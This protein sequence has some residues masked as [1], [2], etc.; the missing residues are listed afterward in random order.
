MI[1][2]D[3][4]NAEK[5][6][7][8]E[9]DRQ[10]AL[11]YKLQRQQEA[12]SRVKQIHN[13]IK[14]TQSV[15]RIGSMALDILKVNQ[16]VK[17]FVSL[18]LLDHD[19]GRFLQM[20]LAGTYK[21]YESEPLIGVAHH[22]T[23][24]KLLLL[25]ELD[26]LYP[27]IGDNQESI[28]KEQIPNGNLFYQ[29]IANIVEGH[30]SRKNS[31]EELGI[32][33]TNLFQDYDMEQILGMNNDTVRAA[34]GSITQLVQDSDRLDIYYQ[35]ISGAWSPPIANTPIPS[36]ILELF[37]QGEYLDIKRIKEDGIWNDNI[38]DLVRLSFI[39]QIRLLSIA[40]VIQNEN[41]IMRLKAARKNPF[42]NEAF[43]Y[44]FE[45]LNSRI[46]SS[47]DG[48]ILGKVKKLN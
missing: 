14:H 29:P 23:L 16:S 28:I 38:G 35:V 5:I 11:I 4:I 46:Q 8:L 25:G 10:T 45:L 36:Q 3:L 26:K 13:K 22:G 31:D 43:D 32:L 19:I 47:E 7:M 41:L 6:F 33:T 40:K 30:V 42:V 34:L 21:D 18:A 48:I 27:L 17:D 2:I 20:R 9:A 1:K 12:A 15:V 44:T 39:S 24:G 37:Y